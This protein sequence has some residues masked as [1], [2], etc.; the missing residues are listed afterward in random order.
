MTKEILI[1][2]VDD[3]EKKMMKRK[4]VKKE[5]VKVQ[6][7]CNRKPQGFFSHFIFL[8]W[9]ESY[10]FLTK[11][12]FKMSIYILIIVYACAYQH[13]IPSFKK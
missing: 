9:Y 10:F 4:M 5:K 7:R 3:E 11:F 2:D 13:M 1:E 6:K 12:V 8:V